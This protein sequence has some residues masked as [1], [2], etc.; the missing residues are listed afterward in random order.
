MKALILAAGFGTRLL[1]YTG[2]IPKP[3]FT[4]LSKPLL[5]HS[6]KKLVDAGCDQILINTHHLY[7]QI[8]AFGEQKKYSINIQ[9]IFEPAILDT[10]G[11]IANAKSFLDKHP[12]FVINADIISTV[13]LK[14]IYA[15]HQKS[16]CMATLV[17]HDHHQFNK[18]GVDTRG[19]V[20]NF[21]SKTN[22][23]A[24][25]GIQVLSPQIYD[26]FPDK[27]IFSSIDVYQS[28]CSQN[29]VK[30]FVETDIFWSDIGTPASYCL[31]SMLTLAASAFKIKQK[32]IKK[33]HIDKLAGDGSDRH[34]YRAIYENQSKIISDHGICMPQSDEWLQ[35][36]AFI[37]IGNHLLSKG[38]PLPRIINHDMLS[39]MV[40][41]ND[42]GDVHLETQIRHKNSTSETLKLYKKVID[43]LIDFSIKGFQGFK[44]EW[45]CQS[46]TYSKELIIE[47]ECRYF[48]E[49]FIQNYL[50]LDLCFHEF[51]NEFDHIADH[52]LNHGFIGLMHRDMQSRNIMIHNGRIYF[53]DFQSARIG[54]LQYDLASLLIDPYVNLNEQ[55]RKDLLQYTMGKLELNSEKR[56]NFLDC[57]QYC[58][59]TRNLQF[60]GAF[61]FLSRIKKKKKFEH[62][63]PDA[64]KSLKKIISNLNTDKI[65]KLTKLIQTL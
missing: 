38:I 10:G 56:Q 41:L 19:Y 17:L 21:N 2:K 62:Y 9:T 49:A 31:T 42:L 61:S 32:K 64:V 20:Q 7:E 29:Q 6:I 22:G 26:H 24:F 28:L 40:I 63:I 27:K 43:L 37:Q 46:E 8:K 55:I 1:P 39:G 3:L 52:A 50:K 35:L 45:T 30:A 11:A 36:N 5:E 65:P 58:C 16:N 51:S 47:K 53:I 12:F 4:L 23:L 15:F 57:Y 14:K 34:W 44:K 18:V 13:D 33:I 54:P 59:L 60:L 48:M 25:T